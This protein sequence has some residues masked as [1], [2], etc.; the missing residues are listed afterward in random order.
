MSF[1][2]SAVIRLLVRFP[3]S[4]VVH[5]GERHRRALV[6]RLVSEGPAWLGPDGVES[7][8]LLALS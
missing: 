2:A 6:G 7:G 3:D 5:I 1:A 8:T 4:G